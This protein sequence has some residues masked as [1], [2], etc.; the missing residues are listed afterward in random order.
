ML[1]QMCHGMQE[2]VEGKSNALPFPFIVDVRDVAKAHIAAAVTQKAK[3]RYLVSNANTVTNSQ[4]IEILRERFPGL[5]FKDAEKEESKP[6]LSND[7]VRAHISLHSLRSRL[8]SVSCPVFCILW[9]VPYIFKRLWLLAA[10]ALCD[11]PQ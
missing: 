4:V 10:N 8:P 6:V 9:Q 5:D 3:G 1:T 11:S 7:K 2:I